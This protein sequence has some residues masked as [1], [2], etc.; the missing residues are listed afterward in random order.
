MTKAESRNGKAE[1]EKCW[2]TPPLNFCFPISALQ[3][4]P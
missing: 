2:L 4:S 3:K 1:I